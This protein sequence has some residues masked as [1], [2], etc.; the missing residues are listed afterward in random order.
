VWLAPLLQTS[1]GLLQP[2]GCGGQVLLQLLACG[3]ASP[4][5][6]PP[7]ARALQ[8]GAQD[9][10]GAAHQV[11]QHEAAAGAHLEVRQAEKGLAFADD[12]CRPA[13]AATG[14]LAGGGRPG[15]R[16]V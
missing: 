6:R 5:L 10:V 2:G 14:R 16:Y 13:A 11:L 7:A 9:A 1:L 12:A 3:T 4:R 8:V 15:L